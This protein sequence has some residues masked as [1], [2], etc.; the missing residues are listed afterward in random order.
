MDI[1]QNIEFSP[2]LLACRELEI[3]GFCPFEKHN[4]LSIR[5]PDCVQA[6]AYGVRGCRVCIKRYFEA[7]YDKRR[8]L[9]RK[10]TAPLK[11][12]QLRQ[13]PREIDLEV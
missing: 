4:R 10:I 1:M 8:G 12:S 13:I 2:F 7:D 6:Q 3:Q 9:R 5:Y 11:I